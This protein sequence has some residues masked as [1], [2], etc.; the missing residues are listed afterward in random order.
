MCPSLARERSKQA[1]S[2]ARLVLMRQT[3]EVVTEHFWNR[4]DALPAEKDI[5]LSAYAFRHSKRLAF[6]KVTSWRAH[7]LKVFGPYLPY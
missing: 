6:K 2:I 1:L 5:E 3:H 4:R 7:D